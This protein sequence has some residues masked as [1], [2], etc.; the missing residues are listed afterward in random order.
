MGEAAN[1]W[2]I[3]LTEG[4]TL[5]GIEERVHTTGNRSEEQAKSKLETA[6]PYCSDGGRCVRALT[7]GKE[8]CCI[9]WKLQPYFVLR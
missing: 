8:M 5:T 4:L 2:G 3:E 1:S 6:L 7:M 9:V